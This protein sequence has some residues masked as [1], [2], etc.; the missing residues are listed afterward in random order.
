MFDS[1]Q[2]ELVEKLNAGLQQDPA[3]TQIE[4]HAVRQTI[5]EN[6]GLDAAHE[7]ARAIGH[8]LNAKLVIWGRKFG[9]KTFY[10]R[11]TV[12]SASKAWSATSERTI[13]AQKVD[14]LR[15]PQE[16]VD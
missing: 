14:E 9:D 16:L 12:V 3:S 2:R 1:L 15:L 11:I 5:D 10:P 6:N 7:R 8:P 4:V 13:D